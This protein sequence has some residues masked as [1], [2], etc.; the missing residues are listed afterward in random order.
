MPRYKRQLN[1]INQNII[2]PTPQPNEH[3][4]YNKN[5]LAVPFILYIQYIV[6]V[7]E[8][9]LYT[10]F[11]N[12]IC[13]SKFYVHIFTTPNKQTVH[14]ELNLNFTHWCIIFFADLF[15]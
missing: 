14:I 13:T 1:S 10:I 3:C 15:Q 8:F 5:K 12:K 4:N 2:N 7:I 11:F 6:L 9:F